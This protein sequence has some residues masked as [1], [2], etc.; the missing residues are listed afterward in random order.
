MREAHRTIAAA[1]FET[2]VPQREGG[3]DLEQAAMQQRAKFEAVRAILQ[4][5]AKIE[6]QGLA[7]AA[8]SETGPPS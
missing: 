3:H 4:E 2:A 1:K 8:K 5:G 6:T 7:A